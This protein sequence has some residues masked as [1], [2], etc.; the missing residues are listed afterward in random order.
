MLLSHYLCNFHDGNIHNEKNLSKRE[1][2]ELQH[3]TKCD[4]L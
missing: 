2:K 4:K 3:I 1:K